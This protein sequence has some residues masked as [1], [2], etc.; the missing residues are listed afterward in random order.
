[1]CVL[2]SSRGMDVAVRILVTGHDGYVGTLLMDMLRHAGHDPVGVDSFFFKGCG[3]QGSPRGAGPGAFRADI[4]CL[5]S[6]A[7][8]GFD[9]VVHLASL[10]HD[11]LGNLNPLL[12]QA[13]NY[14]ASIRLARQAKAEGVTRFVFASS[15]SV[16]GAAGSGMV[17]ED[18]P[19]KPLGPYGTSKLEVEQELTGMADAGFS[20]TVLRSGTAYGVSPRLRG[21]VVVNN[22]VGAALTRGEVRLRSDGTSWRPFVHVEDM[23]RAFLAVLEAPRAQVH[24]QVFNVV[25]E[26]G[27]YQ[28][29]DVAELVAEAFPGCSVAVGKGKEVVDPRSYR[30]DGAKLSQSVPG[31]VPR[32]RMEEG[33]RQLTFVLGRSHLTE[34]DFFGPRFVRLEHIRSLMAAGLLDGDLRWNARSQ[35][36]RAPLWREEGDWAGAFQSPG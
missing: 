8:A 17:S 10:S 26:G 13:I 29:R 34:A 2:P 12:T 6:T 19:A 21:D 24:G 16:Y 32:W 36:E 1:L 31:F 33:I 7:L 23:C 14:R 15:C 9:A 25:P 20:P 35:R 28:V 3:L 4:R 30:V 5:P 11:P 18:A 22:L 27:N